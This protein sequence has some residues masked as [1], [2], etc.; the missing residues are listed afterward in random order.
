MADGIHCSSS[1]SI[2]VAVGDRTHLALVRRSQT[3]ELYIN[4]ILSCTTP[5]TQT[6][7]D[8]VADEDPVGAE[9]QQEPTIQRALRKVSTP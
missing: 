3:F 8:A 4:G 2:A 5:F 6:W 7:Q 9:S 1:A